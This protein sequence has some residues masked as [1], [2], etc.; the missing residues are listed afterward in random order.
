MSKF[1]F[2]ITVE[3]VLKIIK[4]SPTDKFNEKQKFWVTWNLKIRKCE[5]QSKF[6][7]GKSWRSL[8]PNKRFEK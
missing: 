4:K 3:V 8:R 5:K 6:K 2:L 7:V 1:R